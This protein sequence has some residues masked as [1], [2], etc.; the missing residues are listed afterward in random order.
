MVPRN[1]GTIT[2]WFRSLATARKVNETVETK[3]RRRRTI[4][5]A[6]VSPRDCCAEELVN[7][8]KFHALPFVGRAHE[9][10]QLE[11]FGV[12]ANSE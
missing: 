10:Q 11:E 6:R 1:S 4:A 12:T 3:D 5:G 7:G 8:W 2:S 9:W